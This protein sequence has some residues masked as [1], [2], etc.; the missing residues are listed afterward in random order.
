LWTK[1]GTQLKFTTA[2]RP[3]SDG[4][5]E[6][7]NR[8]VQTTLRHF[9]NRAGSDW[10]NPAILALAELGLNSA[11][12]TPSGISP[13]TAVQGYN[14]TIPAT[15]THPQTM[16]PPTPASVAQRYEQLCL[17]WDRAR[18]AIDDAQTTQHQQAT[19]RGPVT[20]TSPF[21]VGQYVLLSTRAYPHL[22]PTKLNAPYVGPYKI[23]ELPSPSTVKLEFPP[24]ADLRIHPVV[25]I[26]SLKLYTAT[27][28]PVPKPVRYS[29]G[30]ALWAIDRILQKRTRKG[31]T[32]YLIRWKGCDAE[33]DSWEPDS[34]IGRFHLLIEQFESTL[35]AIRTTR[36]TRRRRGEG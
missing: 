20:P 35:P 27:N 21:S 11:L 22:R 8:T 31:K 4:R 28:K 23:V 34:E 12:K 9:C 2:H 30:H 24:H 18:H 16:P 13:F 25:N 6:R 14:P 36:G 1:L 15:L 7:S 5:S 32:E 33:Y 3:Q 17:L 26:E 19:E 29:R 10:D